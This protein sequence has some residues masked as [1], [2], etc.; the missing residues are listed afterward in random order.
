MQLR[1]AAYTTYGLRPVLDAGGGGC[2]PYDSG[3]GGGDPFMPAPSAR[4]FQ[5][6]SS[7][8]SDNFSSVR[9]I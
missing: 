7:E 4:T 3:E 5:T 2:W 9:S 8:N 1:V 6:E